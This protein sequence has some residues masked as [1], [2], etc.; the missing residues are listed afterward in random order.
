MTMKRDL[1][2][3]NVSLQAEKYRA[4]K[5][6][7]H[8][9]GE[10]EVLTASLVFIMGATEHIVIIYFIFMII[11]SM[12]CSRNTKLAWSEPRRPSSLVSLISY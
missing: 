1:A 7:A 10:A 11:V 9:T 12:L 5:Y 2:Q 4:I 6:I 8:R 3:G